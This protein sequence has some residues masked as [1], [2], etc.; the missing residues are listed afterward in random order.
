L[1]AATKT[2]IAKNW[3]PQSQE[4]AFWPKRLIVVFVKTRLKKTQSQQ[5]FFGRSFLNEL[6]CPKSVVPA[7]PR[8]PFFIPSIYT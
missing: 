2:G 5:T 4:Y 1:A 7:I 3:F 8:A 6:F